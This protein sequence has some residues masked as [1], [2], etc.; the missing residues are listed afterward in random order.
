MKTL[1]AYL[2]LFFLLLPAYTVWGQT[3]GVSIK[4]SASPPHASAMLDVESNNKGILIPRVSLVAL[5]NSVSPVLSPTTGLLVFNTTTTSPFTQGFYYWDSKTWKKLGSE[6]WRET[7]TANGDIEYYGRNVR[8]GTAPGVGPVLYELDVN[9]DTASFGCRFRVK[10]KELRWGALDYN[11]EIGGGAMNAL[12]QKTSTLV[13]SGCIT[14]SLSSGVGY[15]PMRFVQLYE[16]G[17]WG[18][19]LTSYGKCQGEK[20]YTTMDVT[21][22]DLYISSGAIITLFAGGKGYQFTSTGF[23]SSSDST[24][25]KTIEDETTVMSKVMQC[26]PVTYAY[27]TDV[28]NTMQHGLLAQELLSVFPELVSEMEYHDRDSNGVTLPTYQNK[29][30]VNYMGL[31]TILLKAIQEQQ[32]QIDAMSNRME[33]MER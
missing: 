20:G 5:T 30:A 12:V 18:F 16:T 29:K 8:I 21:K 7:S 15:D 24:L 25:K 4:S 6:L 27:K 17:D 23:N 2:N 13:P 26:R 31:I 3:Q 11:G 19:G 33:I 14:P 22:N 9:G 10:E 1:Q 32:E 28:S